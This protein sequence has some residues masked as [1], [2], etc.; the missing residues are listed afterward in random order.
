MCGSAARTDLYG[1]QLA[2]AVP[3]TDPCERNYR[4]RL[5]PRMMGVETNVRKRM[6]YTRARYPSFEGRANARPT[7]T[8][9]LT[10][11]AKHRPPQIAQP[12]TESP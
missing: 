8:A 5:L 3:R 7:G 4:T 11:T 12:V 2:I 1:G 6:Q 10:A 9:A